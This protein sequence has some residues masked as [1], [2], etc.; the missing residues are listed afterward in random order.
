[1]YSQPGSFNDFHKKIIHSSSQSGLWN[2]GRPET[3]QSTDPNLSCK[4]ANCVFALENGWIIYWFLQM[5]L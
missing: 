2:P 4:H 3:I 5:L 1:M